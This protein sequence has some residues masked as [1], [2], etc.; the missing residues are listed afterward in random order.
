MTVWTLSYHEY[1]PGEEKLRE[2]LCTLGNGVF[3][4]RG[5]APESEAGDRHYPGTYAAGLYNRLVT[6]IQGRPIENEDLVNVPNWLPFTFRLDGGAPF[7]IDRVM[8]HD[9]SQELDLRRGIL[10]RLVEF[11]QDGRRCRLS[12]RRIVSMDNPILAALE[13]TLTPLGWS[14]RI[15]FEG[16]IDGGVQNNGVA[17]YRRFDSRHLVTVDLASRGDETIYLEAET[18]ESH[19]RVAEA[20]RLRLFRD[21]SP[22]TVERDL[23][24]HGDY[25]GQRCTVEAEDGEP[26]R[27]EKTVAL[28]TSRHPAIA[29]PRIAVFQEVQEAGDFDEMLRRHVLAWDH[30]WSCF[31]LIVDASPRA[32]MIINLHIFH[33]LQ[34]VSPHTCEFDVGV[35]ARGWHGEAYRG[36]VFWD[37]LFVLPFLAHRLPELAAGILHYRY[38]RLPAARRAARRAGYEGAMY[39]WQSGSDGREESQVVHLN[40]RS[41]RWIPDN[42]HLQRHVGVAIAYNIWQYYQSTADLGFMARPGTEMLVEIARFWSSITTY[43]RAMDRYRVR[44]VM[45]PDEYHDGYPDRD[46]P[47]LDDNSYTNVMAVWVLLRARE[48]LEL[49]PEDRRSRLRERVGLRQEE[50]ERWEDITRRM[51][52][53]F[54][55]EGIISQFDGYEKLEEFDWEGYRE[56]YG[57]IQRLDRILEAEGDTPNRYKISKQADVLMLFYLL[58]AEELQDIFSRLRYEWRQDTI[59]RNVAYYRR[60][61]SHGST[62]SWVVHAWVLARRDRR[63]SWDLF[64]AAL[65]SDVADI[66]GG[67]TPEGIHLGAMA[68]TVDLVQRC[69]TGMEERGDVLRFDP[70]LPDG[71][72][73]VEFPLL[74]RGHRVHVSIK[75]SEALIKTGEGPPRLAEI[76]VGES[77]ASLGD[78]VVLE[79]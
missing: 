28:V 12:Q 69:Y 33:I 67:T 57:D 59:P 27:V 72:T 71:L 78:G 34:T 73:R 39:P 5:A 41:G 42:S 2:A 23:E 79:T 7:D 15:T 35:P 68:G 30:L 4:T 19:V 32:S 60:R 24:E 62:L 25:I 74:Y 77:S 46:E 11:E 1:R 47:G 70:V 54:H 21:G 49:L 38:R 14:G 17:R 61:T 53:P 75:D 52:I 50:L 31:E 43:D 9:Y 8:I 29:S 66:Q 56:K 58:T 48:A 13:T 20:A 3:A 45:G 65:E 26:I 63:G 16:G 64:Q 18:S 44:G 36:H 51:R 22:V 37:E 76:Q 55:D 40:P 6:E 10:T